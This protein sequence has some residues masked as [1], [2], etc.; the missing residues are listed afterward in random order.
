MIAYAMVGSN[1]VDRARKFF[2]ALMV[3]LDAKPVLE[4][5]DGCMY[6]NGKGAL[7]SVNNPYDGNAACVGNGSMIAFVGESEEQIQRVY[8]KALAL[9]GK[10]EGAPGPRGDKFYAAYFRDVDGNKF[11]I[12]KWT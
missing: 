2:D 4:Y 5:A 3:E 10:N 11:C 6:S 9:G 1:D 12:C 8:I 7:L